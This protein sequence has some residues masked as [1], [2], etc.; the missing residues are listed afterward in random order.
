MSEIERPAGYPYGEWDAQKWAQFWLETIEKHPN[1]PH[2]EGTMIGWF[3]NAIMTG[4]DARLKEEL[5]DA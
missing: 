1:V 2:D 3:A 4:Y 5:G